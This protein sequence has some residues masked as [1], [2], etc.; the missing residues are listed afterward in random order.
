[1]TRSRLLVAGTAVAV[2]LIAVATVL[3]L[4]GSSEKRATAVFSQVVGLYPG[5]QV[6]VVGVPVGTVDAITPTAH[7]VRVELRYAADAPVPDGAQAFILAPTLVT[8]RFV[9]LSAARAGGPRLPDGAVIGL[10]R[11][12]V[13]VEYDELKGQLDE[14]T[15][16]LGPTGVNADGSL[17]RAVSSGARNLAGNGPALNRTVAQ[18][19]AA[20]G[21]LS[22]GR[23]DLFGTVRNLQTAVTALRGADDQVRG[24]TTQLGQLSGTLAGSSADL[25]RA[26]EVVDSSVERI[27]GFVREHRDR[28]GADLDGLSSVTRNLAHNRQALADI[29]Q[30]A[31][32]AVSN[33]Q[34]V[35]DPFSGAIT[36]A[37]AG[38]QLQDVNS[39][40]CSLLFAEGGGFD[41]CRSDLR[42]LL[43]RVRLDYP[44]VA[45]SGVRRNGSLNS[46]TA[47]QGKAPDPHPELQPPYDPSATPPKPHQGAGTQPYLSRGTPPGSPGPRSLADLFP[48]GPAGGR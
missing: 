29:L 16:A 32:S 20:V 40:A 28:L 37:L 47:D 30:I 48:P 43:D 1:M 19:A 4:S 7:G 26:L 17:G 23:E 15:H 14:L 24:F 12:A 18:L 2:V 35:Y 3:L 9:Q 25:G 38:T 8:S 5:D 10:D 44:P 21:A 46:I 11:T 42:P 13:P 34:N 33:F 27:G 39:V 41:G 22:D 31:P 45:F 6:R 36:G